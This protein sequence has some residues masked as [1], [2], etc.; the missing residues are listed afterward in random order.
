[1][2]VGVS[3]VWKMNL[4]ELLNVEINPACVKLEKTTESPSRLSGL[5]FSNTV[6]KWTNSRVSHTPPP[7]PPHCHPPTFTHKNRQAAD[8]SIFLTRHTFSPPH[9]HSKWP[10]VVCSRPSL[11]LGSVWAFE[12]RLILSAAS[13]PEEP[14]MSMALRFRHLM[15]VRVILPA[16]GR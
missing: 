5:L 12:A 3:T 7:P 10:P 14:V 2:D 8:N 4:K 13:S 6:L 1:M 15:T 11:T 16:V 9:F